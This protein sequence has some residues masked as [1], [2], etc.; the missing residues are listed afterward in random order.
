MPFRSMDSAPFSLLGSVVDAEAALFP[1]TIAGMV[2]SKIPFLRSSRGL[3]GKPICEVLLMAER[4]SLRPSDRLI[5]RPGALIEGAFGSFP[6][7]S[8][9]FLRALDSSAAVSAPAY[10]VYDKFFYYLLSSKFIPFLFR[11]LILVFFSDCRNGGICL[12]TIGGV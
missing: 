7:V 3:E 5:L 6:S 2:T 1:F 12:V 8:A 9:V 11:E 4:L 10:E